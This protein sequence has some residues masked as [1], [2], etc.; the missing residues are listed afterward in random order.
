METEEINA[1][2][3]NNI[4]TVISPK[5]VIVAGY[6]F[7]MYSGKFRRHHIGNELTTSTD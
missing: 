2:F 1:D 5:N 4:G 7:R 3:F 6:H